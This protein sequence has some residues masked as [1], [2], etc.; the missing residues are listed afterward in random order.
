MQLL[1]QSKNETWIFILRKINFYF[2]DIG[3]GF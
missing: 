1:I 2:F 3:L